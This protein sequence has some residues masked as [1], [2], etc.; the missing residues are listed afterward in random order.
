MSSTP[1][2]PSNGSS[3]PLTTTPDVVR[4]AASV[5]ALL[6]SIPKGREL[7]D[8]GIAIVIAL[9]NGLR[10]EPGITPKGRK[11]SQEKIA[12]VGEAAIER[13]MLFASER[14]GKAL[15]VDF[16]PDAMVLSQGWVRGG[17]PLEQR[18]NELGTRVRDD[19]IHVQDQD[20]ERLLILVGTMRKR[21]RRDPTLLNPLRDIEAA[22]PK[23]RVRNKR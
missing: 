23:K 20:A 9:G 10:L 11:L 15:D 5:E 7:A 21:A 3:T 16:N 8:A 4:V 17:G 19:V 22:R 18:L 1:N 13:G 14:G 6:R 2:Q 12:T